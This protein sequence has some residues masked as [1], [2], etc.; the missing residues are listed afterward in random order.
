MQENYHQHSNSV[1]LLIGNGLNRVDNQGKN[2]WS[3]ITADLE[4][5]FRVYSDS[6]WEISDDMPLS[7]RMARLRNVVTFTDTEDPEE[8]IEEYRGW[9]NK[10]CQL[11]PGSVL[12]TL[13]SLFGDCNIL[14]TNYDYTIE[15]ALGIKS[16]QTLQKN[17]ECVFVSDI[18]EI[19]KNSSRRNGNV[20]H[21]HG[22]AAVPGS[23]V[24]DQHSY[25]TALSYLQSERE[26]DN[27]LKVFLNSDVHIFGF[28][29]RYDEQLLW[30]ALQ[31]RLKKK[32]RHDVTYYHFVP[33]S[34]KKVLSERSGACSSF[35]TDI[36]LLLM[37]YDVNCI[38]IEVHDK[39][40]AVPDYEAAWMELIGRLFSGLSK[41]RRQKN[42][43]PCEHQS[44]IHPVCVE[45]ENA[46]SG[47]VNNYSEHLMITRKQIPR[48][49]NVSRS[50]TP[51][52]INSK[53]CWFTIV[54]KKLSSENLKGRVW[55]FYIL[56]DGQEYC[57]SVDAE[58]LK[59]KLD[60]LPPMDGLNSNKEPRHCFY[61]NYV[62][63][64]IY[65]SAP[66]IKGNEW[67]SVKRI[68]GDE[69]DN[70]IVK[71]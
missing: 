5:A 24:I 46:Q 47:T 11:E 26:L 17:S 41:E 55:L 45:K 43:S 69:F 38:S 51:T 31:E 52:T 48:G 67:F 44:A 22:E 58:M 34:T 64:K 16:L 35:D 14:T 18:D 6:D 28:T 29:F 68:S 66:C 60:S 70:N 12:K 56:L 27:W 65:P 63:E 71:I 2:G 15:K 32:D 39:Q 49:T 9:L 62:D 3:A 36:K 57:F 23:I 1:C 53:C 37:S 50:M 20:W 7:A 42:S 10:L 54:D 61:L 59:N 25:F 13:L 40:D 4:K 21:I 33:A 19:K 8:G 30:Y